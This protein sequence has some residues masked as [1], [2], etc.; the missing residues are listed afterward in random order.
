MCRWLVTQLHWS[1]WLEKA[2]GW[3]WRPARGLCSPSTCPPCH[4]SCSLSLWQRA[5]ACCGCSL[6]QWALEIQRE[7]PHPSHLFSSDNRA[8]AAAVAA[9]DSLSS[10][11]MGHHYCSA[12][13]LAWFNFWRKSNCSIKYECIVSSSLNDVEIPSLLRIKSTLVQ[14]R[15]AHIRLDLYYRVFHLCLS[16]FL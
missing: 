13:V 16:K 12:E 15:N 14:K 7:R 1:G 5:V 9:V 2:F 11:S 4:A 3:S 8:A 6:C 10:L